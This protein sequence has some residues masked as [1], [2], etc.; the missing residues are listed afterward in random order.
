MQTGKTRVFITVDVECAEERIV[1]GR[2]Q[3]PMGYDLRVWGRFDNA[4]RELGIALLMDELEAHGLR[5]TFFVE[6]LG[7]SFFGQQ[8]LSEVVRA[9]VRRGHDVQLH[10]HPVQRLVDWHTRGIARPSDDIADY[11]VEEQA[12]LLSQGREMLVRAGAREGSIQAFRAGNF[13]ASNDTWQALQLARIPLSS[14]YDPGYFDKSCRMRWDDARA[15]L[16]S[17]REGVWELPITCVREARGKLRHLQ[18]T[19][20][21]APE[22]T[23]A[24]MQS[25]AMGLGE[26]TLVTHS[27]ELCTIDSIEERRGRVNRVNLSRF[28]ALCRFLAEHRDQLEATTLG[29]LAPG[30]GAERVSSIRQMPAGSR[31]LRVRRYAEQG[32]KRMDAGWGKLRAT[33]G[34]RPVQMARHDRQEGAGGMRDQSIICFAKDWTEDPT[35]NNHVM[36]LLAQNNKVLWLN[37]IAAR[38][39]SFSSGRDLGKMARKLR[40]F[41]KGYREVLPNLF[42]YTPIVLPFPHSAAAQQVNRRILQATLATLRR[43]LGMKRFQLWTFLPTSVEY[44]DDL[45]ASLIVY[46]CTD[47]FSQ[48]SYLDRERIM[49]QEARLLRKADVVFATA[50]SLVES[51]GRLNPNTHL[52]SHGV[53]HAHFARALDPATPVAPELAGLRGPVLGFF[54]L[55]QDWIDVD[56]MA[57]IAEQ[58][59]DWNVVVIGRSLVDMSALKRLPNVTLVDRRP[60]EEL[61]RYCRAFSVGL[62]PFRINEL[63]SHVNPIKLREYLSAGLPVVSTDLPEV[64]HYS[65]VCEIAKTRQEFLSACERVLR[66]DTP[67]E[68]QKRSAL[69]LDETWERKVAALGEHVMRALARKG[70]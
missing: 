9:L 40:S 36:R 3:P 42:V 50:H 25:R 34:S 52:A 59:P 68:R 54:G 58:R 4:D 29:E 60:Y 49:H 17:P 66:N 26:V 16:F 48:F 47:E 37:S 23:H 70:R 38:T 30:L 63:T 65:H 2:V 6:P 64:R 12:S 46:Y 27:F 62:I 67:Q 41:T 22:M 7:A 19:A 21:S 53:D 32:L 28:R 15:G 61:P 18:I 39:P 35:S 33:R 57:W 14:S 10:L 11:T 45:G 56:L 8:A 20:V 1:A 31:A 69:M 43:R 51:K 55:V 44:L 24:L 5:A 13:G